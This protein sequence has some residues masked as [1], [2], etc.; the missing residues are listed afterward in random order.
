MCGVALDESNGAISSIKNE[1]NEYIIYV[2]KYTHLS[3]NEF[4]RTNCGKFRI[5]AEFVKYY[6]IIPISSVKSEQ[7][8]SSANFYQRKE[9][10]SLSAK[11]L[12]FSMILPQHEKLKELILINAFLYIY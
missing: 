6:C 4:W 12:K 3:L 10:S 1:L 8:F 2:S 9:R 11:N 5:L 7:S